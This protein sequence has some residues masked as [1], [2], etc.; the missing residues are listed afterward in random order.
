VKKVVID[1]NIILTSISR[2]S[3]NNWIFQAIINGN[4]ELLV[5][6]EILLEYEEVISRHMGQNASRLVINALAVLPNVV[7]PKVHYKWNILS[8][9]DDNKFIDCAV[10]GNAE[11]IV[12]ND[13]DFNSVKNIDFPKILILSLDQFELIYKRQSY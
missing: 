3:D 5:T 9:E 13:K 6:T 7:T 1:T 2:R 8:D 10:A 12:T 11:C 4:L